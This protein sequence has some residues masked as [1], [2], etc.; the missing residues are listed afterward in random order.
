MMADEIIEGEVKADDS[1]EGAEKSKR[2]F[3]LLF[4]LE[5]LA[6]EGRKIAFNVLRGLISDDSKD[7]TKEVFVQH[8]LGLPPLQYLPNVMASSGKKRG[9][10]DKLAAEIAEGIA[11]SFGDGQVTL[12]KGLATVLEEAKKEGVVLGCLSMLDQEVAERLM[13]KLGLATMGAKLLVSSCDERSCP[14]ADAWLKLAKEIGLP[15][16][17]CTAL[18]S[19]AASSRAAIAAGMRSGV[20]PDEFTS[21]E[22]FGGADLVVDELNPESADSMLALALQ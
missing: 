12:N 17:R 9:S 20:V 7:V 2:A 13:D 14:T 10:T 3:G 1:A 4:E 6:A 11:F 16:V 22:D 5:N 18:S 15:P 19:S 21:F 8:C